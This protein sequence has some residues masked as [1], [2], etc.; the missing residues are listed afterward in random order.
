MSTARKVL[1]NTVVQVVGRIIMALLSILI[2]K[3]ITNY[4][5]VEGY[6]QYAAIYEFLAF[7]GIAAD[8]GLFTIAVREMAKED[9]QEGKEHVLSNVLTLRSILCL[10]VL[11]IAIGVAYLVPQY[12]EIHLGI[13]IA[14][15]AVFLAILQSTVSSLLQV[16]LKMQ[17][18]SLAQVVGKFVALSYMAYTVFYGFKEPSSAGFYNLILAG[19]IGNSV[20]LLIT[21]LFARRYGKIRFGRDFSYIKRVLLRCLP[22]GIALVLNM[23]YFR[24]GSILLLVMKGPADVGIY[25]VPMRILEILSLV[26]V[27][28]MNSVLPVLT[29]HIKEGT[30]RVKDILKYSFDFLFMAAVPMVIGAF[31]L[32]YPIVFVISSEEF[33]SRVDEGFYGSDIALK[34]L[35]VAMM[36]AFINAL[37][38]YS[39]IATS[40]QN[41][42]LWI[43]GSCAVF[44]VCLNLLTIPT[45][46]FRGAAISAIA[47]EVLL[48]IL[49]STVARRYLKFTFSFETIWKVVLSGAMMGLVVWGLRDWTYEIMQNANIL[50][51][52][53][54]GGLVYGGMMLLTKG[55]SRDL[56]Q[57]VRR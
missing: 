37:F 48:L 24:M 54:I 21:Y 3:L 57:L 17:Y 41:K 36:I 6:G 5:G 52:V 55:V 15:A 51:L 34:F 38:I 18:A 20:L 32:A 30:E 14:S 49:A 39:I 11:G 50:V 42:L 16:N 46:G 8:L 40:H 2:V 4:L 23:I 47:T 31:I 29:R 12:R 27:F 56:I 33:L 13:V 53:P 28:F 35:M 44:N 19:V 1:D 22:Y 9:T 45:W 26:P 7:F 25:S 43:N 10:V